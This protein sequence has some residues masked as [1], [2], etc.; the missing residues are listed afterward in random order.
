MNRVSHKDEVS[1][2]EMNE[3]YTGK[4]V[5]IATVEKKIAIDRIAKRW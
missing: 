5:Y 2:I 3:K 1:V 4:V